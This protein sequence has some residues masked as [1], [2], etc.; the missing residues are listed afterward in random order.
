[1]LFFIFA[2]D[3]QRLTQVLLKNMAAEA[4][5]AVFPRPY[6]KQKAIG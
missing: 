6:I 3:T 1:M 4:C 2:V 5:I